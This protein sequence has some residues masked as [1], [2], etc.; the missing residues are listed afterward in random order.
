MRP[1]TF[2]CLFEVRLH[3][4]ANM[5]I[6]DRLGLDNVRLHMIIYHTL[7]FLD[8]FIQASEDALYQ[9][10]LDGRSCGGLHHQVP[11]FLDDL[12]FTFE[13]SGGCRGCD[14]TVG[15]FDR[16]CYLHRG[17]A[18]QSSSRSRRIVLDRIQHSQLFQFV[19]GQGNPIFLPFS[20]TG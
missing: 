20:R 4:L 8:I 19:G 15:G 9:R 14:R 18:V 1:Y 11:E 5:F 7:E 6:D 12:D 13:I 3:V 17:G 2:M 16:H 10:I